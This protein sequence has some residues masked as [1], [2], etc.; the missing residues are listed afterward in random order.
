MPG[1]DLPLLLEDRSGLPLYQQ[2]SSAIVAAIRRGRLRPGDRLPGTRALADSLEVNRNTVIAAYD[3]LTGEGWIE[4]SRARG[5]FVSRSLPEVRPKAFARSA[6]SR[7]EVPD[8]AGF[9]FQ[10][11]S[12]RQ[13]RQ[14]GNP[15]AFSISLGSPDVRLTPADL[16]ARAYRRA[17]RRQTES[18]LKYGYTGGHPVLREALASMLA[19]TRGLA[20]SA[21]DVLITSGSQMALE[22]LGR[23]LL[24]KGDVVAVEQIGYRPAWNAFQ[25]HGAKVVPIPVDAGGMDVEALTRLVQRTPVR[26]VYVTPHHQYPTTATLT[27]GR[28]IALLELARKQRIA[29]IEDDYDHEYHYEGRP[30]LPLASV[31]DAGVVIYI[32]TLTKV[33]APGVR[34]G[35]TAAPRPLLESMAAHRHIIDRQ[36]DHTLEYAVA[37]LIEEGAVQRHAR[38]ARRVYQARRDSLVRV[39]RSEFADTLSFSVPAG[40]IAVWAQAADG[41]DVDAWGE[42]VARQGVAMLTAKY[43][44]FDGRSRPFIRLGF[45]SLTEEEMSEALARLRRVL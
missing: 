41:I 18:V 12:Q 39:L 16:L 42:R 31:D 7:K 10:T 17:I 43:Y 22:L 9:A 19:A 45:A 26:A 36:G 30:V 37:E 44:A 35:Y 25:Q 20:T 4:S 24:R 32:G 38:R 11:T 13:P 23:T 1:P 29:I 14:P 6:A 8:A 33:I 21:E 27:A 40:G 3:E 2:I 28:R 34:L 5:S 15:P